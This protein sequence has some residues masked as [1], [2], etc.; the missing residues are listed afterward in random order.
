MRHSKIYHSAL[1]LKKLNP[2][3]TLEQYIWL[4]V[5]EYNMWYENINND[6]SLKYNLSSFI[7]YVVLPAWKSETQSKFTPEHSKFHV[8]REAVF[9]TGKNKNQ[10]APMISSDIRRWNIMQYFDRSVSVD[11][12][13]E[14]FRNLGINVSRRTL[15]R[16]LK[17]DAQERSVKQEEMI[18]P[19]A[20]LDSSSPFGE[21]RIA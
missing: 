18:N 17:K 16:Y 21:W 20:G 4:I 5:N 13:L 19:S 1:A 6:G 2:G 8:N 12:N 7:K 14:R 9:A 10:L 15:F 3:L 11:E